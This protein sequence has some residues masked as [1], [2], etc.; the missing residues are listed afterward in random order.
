MNPRQLNRLINVLRGESRDDKET[1]ETI[2]VYKPLHR[3]V[4]AFKQTVSGGE[5]RRGFKVESQTTSLF[6]IRRIDDLDQTMRIEDEDGTEL[7]ITRAREVDGK[8]DWMLVECSE[9]QE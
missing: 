8:R 7:E 5:T 6:T 4:P 2:V 9:V 1:G 3:K